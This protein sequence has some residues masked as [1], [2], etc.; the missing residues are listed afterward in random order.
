MIGLVGGGEISITI[1]PGQPNYPATTRNGIVAGSWPAWN[2]GFSFVAVS[3]MSASWTTV[4]AEYRGQ[5]DRVVAVDCPAG[6][7][8]RNIWGTDVY[9]DDSS[10]CSAAVHAGL[11]TL[12]SG[13]RVFPVI[14]AGRASYSASAR[15]GISSRSYGRWVGSFGFR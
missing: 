5:N 14:R 9:T 2:R 7:A 6:G 8:A 3:A 4:L 12:S 10:V 13:G 1:Q 11:I 15:Y